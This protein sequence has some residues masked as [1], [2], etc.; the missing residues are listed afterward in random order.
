MSEWINTDEELAPHV[1]ENHAASDPGV[2]AV[3]IGVPENAGYETLSRDW[4]EQYESTPPYLSQLVDADT[5]VYVGA[6]KSVRDRIEEHRKG[7]VRKASL[8][9]IWGITDVVDVWWYTDKNRAFER[10]NYHA[11]ELAKE[12]PADTYVHSR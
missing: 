7:K 9:R 8:P 11:L 6:S 4:L 1:T 2:Y 12:T 5:V 10:E 3:E